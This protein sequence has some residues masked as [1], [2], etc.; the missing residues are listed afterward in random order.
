MATEQ[1]G[2]VDVDQ[3]KLFEVLHYDGMKSW[4]LVFLESQPTEK[5]ESLMVGVN[6][7]AQE[8][9]DTRAGAVLLSIAQTVGGGESRILVDSYHVEAACM[10]M[11]LAVGALLTA[12]YVV[13][14]GSSNPWPSVP[15]ELRQALRTSAERKQAQ[16]AQ[17]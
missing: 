1:I 2:A 9:D 14:G 11:G 4:Q 7:A 3:S 15:E 8:L 10:A 17:V 6:A 5:L 16:A 12:G 13:S